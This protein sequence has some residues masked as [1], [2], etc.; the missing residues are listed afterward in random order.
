M[1]AGNAANRDDFDRNLK[2]NSQ[3]PNIECLAIALKSRNHL[4]S[5]DGVSLCLIREPA[6]AFLGPSFGALASA[7]TMGNLHL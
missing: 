2:L 5:Q 3:A 4:P 7:A 6:A 1:S